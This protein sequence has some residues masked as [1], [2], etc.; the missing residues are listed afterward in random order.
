MESRNLEE[1]IISWIADA[2]SDNFFFS[3]ASSFLF[4]SVVQNRGAHYKRVNEVGSGMA[5]IWDSPVNYVDSLVSMGLLL[6][7][8][9]SFS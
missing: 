6:Y 3:S 1:L 9:T 7:V 8:R 4:F 2:L 5:M